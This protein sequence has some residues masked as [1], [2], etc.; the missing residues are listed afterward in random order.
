MKVIADTVLSYALAIFQLP[1][2]DMIEVH[3]R[4]HAIEVED[5]ELFELTKEERIKKVF[6]QEVISWKGFTFAYTYANPAITVSFSKKASILSKRVSKKVR[7]YKVSTSRFCWYCYK[8]QWSLLCFHDQIP[9]FFNK[10]SEEFD[11]D[12]R[13]YLEGFHASLLDIC[14]IINNLFSYNGAANTVIL[15]PVADDCFSINI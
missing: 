13:P 3:K 4:K 8:S 12:M 15:E 10:V 7:S 1:K 6:K 5:I 14:K 11:D 2:Q 9:K